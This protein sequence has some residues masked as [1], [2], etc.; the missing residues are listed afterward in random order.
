[1]CA[2]SAS[3]LRKR[4]D[5]HNGLNLESI[6]GVS[7]GWE[8]EDED[9]K[10]LGD[11][12]DDESVAPSEDGT[13]RDN[14]DESTYGVD[15]H[16]NDDESTYGGDDYF[17]ED[18]DGEESVAPS[19]YSSWPLEDT[20]A[21]CCACLANTRQKKIGW[22]VTGQCAPCVNKADFREAVP[23]NDK[24]RSTSLKE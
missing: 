9:A 13:M 18:N 19:E 22:S 11:F 23:A 7:K 8:R 10:A 24:C 14:D 16:D 6:A 17:Y 2:V 20:P 5:S 4:L 21:K 3:R 15:A 12:D 1:M